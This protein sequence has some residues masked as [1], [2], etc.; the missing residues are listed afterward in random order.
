[1]L[2]AH[3]PVSGPHTLPSLPKEPPGCYQGDGSVS[4]VTHR[5][6]PPE[7]SEQTQLLLLLLVTS[8]LPWKLLE[9][10][11]LA[12]PAPPPCCFSLALSITHQTIYFSQ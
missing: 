8:F 4:Q 2:R 12:T 9:L 10:Q 1:M 5:A 7:G 6:W 3:R 11:S